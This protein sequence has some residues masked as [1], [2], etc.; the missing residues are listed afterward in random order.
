MQRTNQLS[1][2][3]DARAL[4]SAVTAI[5]G[6]RKLGNVIEHRLQHAAEEPNCYDPII[7]ERFEVSNCETSTSQPQLKLQISTLRQPVLTVALI[8]SMHAIT[9]SCSMARAGFR[10]LDL[11]SVT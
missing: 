6:N 10:L 8:A 3:K 1:G 9:M 7:T 5:V 11:V 2:D 4:A